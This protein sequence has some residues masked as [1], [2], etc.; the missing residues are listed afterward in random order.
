MTRSPRTLLAAV[1]VSA[2]LLASCSSSDSDGATSSTTK[3]PGSSTTTTAAKAEKLQILVVND[4]GYQGDG[5][6]A[7][8]QGLRNLPDVELE[9]V[10]PAEN[11]SGTGGKATEGKL[12]RSQVELNSGFPATAVEGYPVDAVRVAFDDLK[13]QPDLV[14]SG[15]YQGQNLGPAADISGTV[16]AAREAVARGVPALA[17]SQGLAKSINYAAAVSI[18]VD[19]VQDQREA[20]L[21][22]RAEAQVD[23]INVPSC[24]EGEPRGLAE[25]KAD[26]G[27]DMAR[28]LGAQDCASTV[29][30][31]P[32]TMTDVDAFLIGYATHTLL[33]ATAGGK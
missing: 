8:V 17:V 15:I 1:L 3:A 18:V 2:A 6:D 26:L 24:A 31:D 29:Q 11:Q 13:V 19:W 14:V 10:A 20:L 16:G 9:V 32:A 22:G 4:D 12:A 5:I 30:I 23:N 27:G 21:D 25:V 28:S 7:V 33:P